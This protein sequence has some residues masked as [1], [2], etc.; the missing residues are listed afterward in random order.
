MGCP[1]AVRKVVI[2][3]CEIERKGKV[4]ESVTLGHKLKIY[5]GGDVSFIG[6]SRGIQ[7][8]RMI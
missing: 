7:E 8:K 6:G 2:R 5:E 3:G 1:I 4:T